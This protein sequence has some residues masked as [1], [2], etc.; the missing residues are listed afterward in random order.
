MQILKTYSVI[1]WSHVEAVSIEGVLKGLTFGGSRS[2]DALGL[3][4]SVHI[5]IAAT[6]LDAERLNTGAV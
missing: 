4:L 3:H 6:S 5:E 2:Q 1:P